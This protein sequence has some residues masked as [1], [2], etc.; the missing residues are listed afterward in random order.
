MQAGR[1][2]SHIY[3]CLAAGWPAHRVGEG[4]LLLACM[5]IHVTF[6]IYSSYVIYYLVIGR[7]HDAWHVQ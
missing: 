4:A 5:M 7:R 3:M 1:T 6:S 2:S